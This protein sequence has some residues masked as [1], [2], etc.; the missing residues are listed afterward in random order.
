[1]LPAMRLTLGPLLFPWPLAD[2]RDFYAR[3][4]D[5]AEVDEVY[6]GEVVC[7]KR[8]RF[9][10]PDWDAIAARL[11]AGGKRVVRSTLAEVIDAQDRAV[12]QEVCALP[13]EAG[14]VEVGDATALA[15]RAGRAHRLGP[16]MN[17]YNEGA[18]RFL[19]ARGATHATAPAEMYRE[20]LAPLA[21]AARA[22]G[23]GLEVQVFGRAPLALS[24]RCHGA[25]AVGRARQGCRFACGDA[26]QG[27][28]LKTLEGEDL[29]VVNGVQVLSHG[30]LNLA[31]EVDALRAMGV[32]HLRLSPHA[33]DMVAVARAFA[34]RVR[35]GADAA[36]VGARLRAAGVD[37]PFSN[38]FFHH[39]PGRAWVEDPEGV[40]V[41]GA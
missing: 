18:L 8:A 29:V 39:R 10:G 36:E 31:G 34:A 33:V 7:A 21:D 41:S 22:L 28:E 9:V 30:F 27:T 24:A 23:A 5:E 37:A 13:D 38:G 15:L 32:T 35:G 19:A 3:I 17:V 40:V 12:V 20:A 1:M 16:H 6:I 25:R 26:P 11:R 14:E 2:A 4:A